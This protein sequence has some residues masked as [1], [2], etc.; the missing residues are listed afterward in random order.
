MS[1]SAGEEGLE[2][3]AF[4][5]P[6]MGKLRSFSPADPIIRGIK[7]PPK[8]NPFPIIRL[9]SRCPLLPDQFLAF[10]SGPDTVS[11]NERLKSAFQ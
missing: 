6:K 8:P 7:K 11:D 2:V 9:A 4:S 10:I 5:V 3:S 1:N